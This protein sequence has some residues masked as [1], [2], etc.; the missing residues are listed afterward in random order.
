MAPPPTLLCRARARVIGGLL[1]AALA[2]GLVGA[3]LTYQL[4][5]G[6][7]GWP[8]DKRAAIVSAMDAAVALYNSYGHFPRNLT[9]N[10]NASVPTAQASYSGWIDFGG[11]ISTRVALHEISHTLGIGTYSGWDPFLSGGAWTGVHALARVRVFDGPAG[12]LNGD[13]AHFWPYGLNYDNEDSTVNRQRHIKMVSAFRRD[14]GLVADSDGDGLPDDWEQFR[15]KGLGQTGAGDFDADGTNNLA[16][17]N[18]DADPAQAFSFTW[19]GGAG[20]WDTA[21]TNWTGAAT[22]WRNGGND[23]AVFGGSAGSVTTAAG[24]A[25]SDLTFNSAG[26]AI[27]GSP[28]QL[29]GGTSV[30]TTAAG[31]TAT[32]SVVLTGTRPVIKAG[33]GT[34]RLAAVNTFNSTTLV[35]NGTLL[36]DPTGGLFGA[37]S[38]GQLVIGTGAVVSFSGHFGYTCPAFR[39][40]P[41]EDFGLVIHGGT[42]RHTGPSNAKTAQPGAGRLFTIGAAG[43]TLDSATAG[44][45]FSIGYRYDYGDTLGGGGGPLTLTGVGHGDL[46]LTVPGTGALVKAGAGRWKLTATNRYTGP[47]TVQAG[48]LTVA[49]AWSTPSF[50]IASG[51]VLELDSSIGVTSRPDTVLSGAGTLRKSGTNELRWAAASA[52]FALDAG[53][54]IEVLQ[55]DFIGGSH[56]DEIWT[57]NRAALHVAA[58]AIFRG[59]EAN[60]RVDALTGGG[61]IGS[62]YTGAGYTS[63]T[64]GVAGGSGVFSGEL[65]NSTSAGHFV[66]TGT[67]TQTLAGIGTYT[68]STTINGGALEV[69]G[70]LASPRV[71]V[72]SNALL[73]GRGTLAGVVTNRG[74]V[75]PGAVPNPLQVGGYAQSSNGTL[76]IALTSPTN[77]GALVVTGPVALAGALVVSPSGF[78]PADG[79]AFTVLTCAA[80]SGTFSSTNLPTLGTAWLWSVTYAATG[81]V[82]AVS[83][84]PPTGYQLWITAITNGLT[85]HTDSASG[86]GYANLLKY[87]TGSS[88][89]NTDDR[90]RLAID[91]TG[92][93]P[94]LRFQRD[95]N[96]TDVTLIVEA[97]DALGPGA[98]WQGL[99]T[100][101]NGSWGGESNVVESGA[102]SP[103]TVVAEDPASPGGSRILRLRVTQP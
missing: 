13:T 64:F 26:Y 54:R 10:Y 65:A 80:R 71:L 5:G 49:R 6:A 63:F 67:G 18:A 91:F 90:A 19:K 68:G 56:A 69:D 76:R 89:T 2:P 33:S 30:L 32:V 102:G 59:V 94:G 4:A 37:Y 81:V 58:G 24:L 31:V 35:A 22:R 40:L 45:E 93:Q 100:N 39:G 84:P 87:A 98:T 53:A 15:F 82:L 73:A 9:A 88:P 7:D 95:T 42:L 83:R 70:S 60:V 14:M 61:I 85:N 16:E 74:H 97:A 3:Q 62:G 8:A 36:I 79:Q 92:G 43:A 57:S 41:V 48:T 96:A 99:F 25:G 72:L 66:K 47:T 46:N 51:A 77:H 34:L 55:G 101:R 78:V 23:L 52:T 1:L 28:F 44:Q 17:Y 21:A 11:S 12:T 29:T 20:A 103:R 86:D 50:A 75:S 38:G 27:T